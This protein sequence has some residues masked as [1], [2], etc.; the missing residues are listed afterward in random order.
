MGDVNEQVAR[1][2][3][4][5][6]TGQRFV[7]SAGFRAPPDVLR[8]A[9]PPKDVKALRKIFLEVAE[10]A[11]LEPA[12]PLSEPYRFSKPALWPLSDASVVRTVGL[13]P[14]LNGV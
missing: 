5:E 13:E 4:F 10:A 8:L 7:V 1:R 2:V 14:T 6:P 9:D 3:G 11:G 12:R